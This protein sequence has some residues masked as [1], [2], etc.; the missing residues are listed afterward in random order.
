MPSR[1]SGKT[2]MRSSPIE[3]GQFTTR[4]FMSPRYRADSCFWQQTAVN[5]TRRHEA[6]DR[7]TWQPGTGGPGAWPLEGN[8]RPVH[9]LILP[10]GVR[11]KELLREAVSVAYGT[12]ATRELELVGS[13]YIAHWYMT[14]RMSHETSAT[15]PHITRYDPFVQ[16]AIPSIETAIL[17]PAI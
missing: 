4:H 1:W 8:N 13:I 9:S 2:I 3:D 15:M 7:R 12:T 5:I 17:K 11:E 10:S 14:R 6:R 16:C